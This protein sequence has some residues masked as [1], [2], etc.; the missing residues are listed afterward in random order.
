MKKIILTL[1]FITISGIM[2]YAECFRHVDSRVYSKYFNQSEWGGFWVTTWYDTEGNYHIACGLTNFEPANCPTCG[3]P[4]GGGDPTDDVA[5]AYLYS[6]ADAS[7]YNE[8]F[9]ATF[10]AIYQVSGEANPRHY[11]VTMSWTGIEE[12]DVIQHFERID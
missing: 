8:V 2:S 5:A 12:D 1:L 10:N 11:R 7:A 4:P 3:A 6:Q 9:D